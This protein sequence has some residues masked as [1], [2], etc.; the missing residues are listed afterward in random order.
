MTPT[1]C[2]PQRQATS[3]NRQPQLRATAAVACYSVKLVPTVAAAA[4][5]LWACAR[6]LRGADG[7]GFGRLAA[8]GPGWSGSGESCSSR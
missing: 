3:C 6:P 7:E 4:D 2:K 5:P 8:V 1:C